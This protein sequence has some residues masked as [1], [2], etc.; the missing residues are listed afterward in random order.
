MTIAMIKKIETEVDR[1]RGKVG[2]GMYCFYPSHFTV[3]WFVQFATGRSRD[4]T[5]I[6]F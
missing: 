5:V 2:K 1:G 3:Y 4:R 6:A